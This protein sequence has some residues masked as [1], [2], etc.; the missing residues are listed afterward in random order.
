MTEPVREPALDNPDTRYA[1]ALGVLSA[2]V[3]TYL[4]GGMSKERFAEQYAQLVADFKAAS[5]VDL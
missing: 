4:D 5:G 3:K 1:F 2:V